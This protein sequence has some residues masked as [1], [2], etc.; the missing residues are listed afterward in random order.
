[1]LRSTPIRASILTWGAM[2]PGLVWP[3]P[4]QAMD[5]RQVFRTPTVSVFDIAVQDAAGLIHQYFTVLLIVAG[6]LA[7]A[8]AL[9]YYLVTTLG[10]RIVSDLRTRVFEHLTALSAGFFDSAKSGE[11]IS[12][13]SGDATQLKSA[14]GASVSITLRNLL[15]FLA[16]K[17]FCTTFNIPRPEF[18]G[19]SD[20]HLEAADF[21]LL[22]RH[23][24]SNLRKVYPYVPQ[25]L[26][27]VLM[28]FS[29]ASEVFYFTVGELLEDL[30]PAV[31]EIRRG[32]LNP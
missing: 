7:A 26:N 9:R 20:V 30:L 15:L 3:G 11:L 10:E 12:R 1:M 32:R 14:V 13:L 22:F 28:H 31:D 18:D 16:G 5:G 6:V 24:L 27:N 19:L 4:A 21:S 2:V 17:K 23:R 8:S 29:S 25:S